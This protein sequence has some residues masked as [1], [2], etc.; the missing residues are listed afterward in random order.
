L[1]LLLGSTDDLSKHSDSDS[2][3]GFLPFM[4]ASILIVCLAAISTALPASPRR[5][6]QTVPVS[7]KTEKRGRREVGIL[8]IAGRTA[9]TVKTSNSE[10]SPGDRA[11]TAASRLRAKL[12]GGDS[13]ASIRAIKT[14]GRWSV[15]LGDTPLIYVTKREARAQESDA[16]SLARRWAAQIRS[17]VTQPALML[18]SKSVVV[19]LNEARSIQL[20]GWAAKSLKA[21]IVDGKGTASARVEGRT[22][23]VRGAAPGAAKVLVSAGAHN[24]SCVIHVKK[25][26]GSLKTAVTAQVTGQSAP[27][28]LLSAVAA[29]AVK[30]S[31]PREAGASIQFLSFPKVF[32]SLAAGKKAVLSAKVQISGKDYLPVVGQARIEVENAKTPPRKTSQLM[33]SNVPEQITKAGTLYLAEVPANASGRLFYHHIN[34]AKAPATLTVTL[35]NPEST[36]ARLH[37][38]SGFVFPD[39]DPVQ[40]GRAA[41]RAFFPR[42]VKNIGEIFIL[43][44]KSSVPLVV[45]LLKPQ[46][47]GSGMAEIRLLGPDSARFFV[48]VAA[49]YKPADS[50]TKA[51]AW[52][53]DAWRSVTPRP[54]TAAE[55]A[56]APDSPDLYPTTTKVVKAEYTVGQKWTWI[57]FGKEPITD[58]AGKRPLQ[59]NYGVLYNIDLRLHNPGERKRQVELAFEA[60][61]GPASGIFAIADQFIEVPSIYPRE[62]K[63]L[64][65]FTL[66][67]NQT[68]TISI[69]T[70]PLGGSAY[71]ANLIVR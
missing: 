64:A 10:M 33:Y 31:L 2:E 48:R 52:R 55:I 20:S 40:A 71:P 50:A 69:Q 61:A 25:Y 66:G 7:A 9:L 45:D 59:G 37:L 54:A 58:S 51:L 56:H 19:P 30:R 17:L 43:P 39:P 65:K 62:E 21:S 35:V 41:G 11:R 60:G 6:G 46:D 22:L 29:H 68:R 3:R 38:V 42:Y 24:A 47:V 36:P 23:V 5:A 49:S 67:P 70:V 14:E 8:H 44:P 12:E 26:A 16:D 1:P 18:A 53:R 13:A 32:R 15:S 27:P 28:P 63:P 57:P 34:S 4:R